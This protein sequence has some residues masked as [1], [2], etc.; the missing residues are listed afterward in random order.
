M[1]MTRTKLIEAIEEQREIMGLTGKMK[2]LTGL[3]KAILEDIYEQ[4]LK[5][6]AEKAQNERE[7]ELERAYNSPKKKCSKCGR[8][9]PQNF[10]DGQGGC[11]DC[12][13]KGLGIFKE[14]NYSPEFWER[15]G[16]TVEATE[17]SPEEQTEEMSTEMFEQI[18]RGSRSNLDGPMIMREMSTRMTSQFITLSIRSPS[19]H[20]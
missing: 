4:G 15:A 13:Q 7:D 12:H 9:F 17:A 16:I 1:R 11:L 19:S 8:E 14:T 2:G 10:L 3:R 18:S 5:A 20:F 6:L